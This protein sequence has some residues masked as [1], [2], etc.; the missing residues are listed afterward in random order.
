MNIIYCPF[1]N[2][3]YYMN[4]Q[5]QKVALDVQ[6]LETQ[7]LLT[8]LALHAG[9][10]Q[11]I[12]SYPERLK[13]YHKALLTYDNDNEGN[14]FH[15]SI[16]IDSMSVAK[17]LLGWR[18]YLALCGWNCGIV[19]KDCSRLNALAEIEKVYDDKGLAQL[20]I[21]LQE[22]LHLMTTGQATIPTVYKELTIEVPC[23]QNLLPE[24]IQPILKYLKDIGV[25]I[26]ENAVDMK[27]SMN[28]EL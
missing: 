23:P 10:H 19:L 24:Y 21:K 1:Y 2:G 8:Q 5:A 11:Q 28:N 12:P 16:A 27:K 3:N 17:T 26:E 4:M 6:V 15:K 18:D 13:D 22:Q 7:G 25:T 14:I 20:L 9:I